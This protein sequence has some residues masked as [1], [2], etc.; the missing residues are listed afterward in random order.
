MLYDGQ[1][2]Y[3]YDA[4][5]RMC[6][7]QSGISG[8]VTQYIYN[9]EGSRVAK[10]TAASLSCYTGGTSSASAQFI[11]GP[12]GEQLTE[13]DGSGAWQHTNVFTDGALLAT[14]DQS[15]FTSLCL[16]HSAQLGFRPPRPSLR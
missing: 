13:V 11:L 16:T 14:Y 6:A 15:G 3:A 9:A 8:A 7:A 5:G 1:N 12:S 10:A 4:E 2:N